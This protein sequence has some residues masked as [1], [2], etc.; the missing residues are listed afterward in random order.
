EA[1]EIPDSNGHILDPNGI[2]AVAFTATDCMK[3]TT[4]DC[5]RWA[6]SKGNTW[7]HHAVTDTSVWVVP[8]TFTGSDGKK[9]TRWGPDPIMLGIP[10][11]GTTKVKG[12]FVY[13]GMIST[14]AN[15]NQDIFI[16]VSDDGGH[17]FRRFGLVT[18]NGGNGSV[19]R[20]CAA[21]D[22]ENGTIWVQWSGA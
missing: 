10:R 19:D 4:G 14:S 17:S 11:S 8:S 20:P 15:T 7:E 18:K 6:H 13:I 12:R 5:V 3:S 2:V 16:A 1:N 22:R 9:I 21:V